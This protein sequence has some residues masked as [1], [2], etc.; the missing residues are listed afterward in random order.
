MFELRREVLVPAPIDE[1]FEFFSDPANLARITPKSLGFK[2][3]TP[4][5]GPM[6]AGLRIAHQIKVFGIPQRWETLIEEFDPPHG[7]VDRQERGPYKYWRH[8]H[9]FEEAPGG[10]LMRDH[11]EYEVPFG[12]LGVIANRLIVA[13]QL[14]HIFDYRG[15][16][17]RK[18]F[19]KKGSA[20]PAE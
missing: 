19:A 12:P 8:R 1:V 5:A 11:V 2:N 20:A 13:R 16:K 15:R 4:D 10:T 17:I 7:F 6:S 9:S 18:L 14:K 3:L